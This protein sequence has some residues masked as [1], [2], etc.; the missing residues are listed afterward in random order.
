MALHFNT[1]IGIRKKAAGFDPTRRRTTRPE[2]CPSRSSRSRPR[3]SGSSKRLVDGLT[4][5]VFIVYGAINKPA[6][7]VGHS[8]ISLAFHNN[9]FIKLSYWPA[10]VLYFT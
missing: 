5:E 9:H 6:S 7:L 10:L 1:A 8:F 3:Q 2:R 4:K